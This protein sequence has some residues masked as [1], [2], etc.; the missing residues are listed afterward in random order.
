MPVHSIVVRVMIMLSF[1]PNL[2]F[3]RPIVSTACCTFSFG[4]LATLFQWNSLPLI[5]Q[6]P[7][8]NLPFSSQHRKQSCC[9]CFVFSPTIHREHQ[10]LQIIVISTA[11]IFNTGLCCFISRC[12]EY[13]LV[14]FLLSFLICPITCQRFG[15]PQ[16]HFVFITPVLN[17]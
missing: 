5:K 4:Y 8:S 10:V 7:S 6:I 14:L 16:Y 15:S 12:L 17:L 13:T 11:T 9:A 2:T 1:T 3:G